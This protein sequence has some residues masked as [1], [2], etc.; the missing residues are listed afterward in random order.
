MI[1][2]KEQISRTGN[3]DI[4]LTSTNN[5]KKIRVYYVAGQYSFQNANQSVMHRGE[6][7][8]GLEKLQM[9]GW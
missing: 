4:L 3:T 5:T 2:A 1:K 6:Y 8:T 9:R 7:H